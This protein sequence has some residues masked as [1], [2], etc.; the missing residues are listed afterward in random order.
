M[1][2]WRNTW[3]VKQGKMDE[4]ITA[5]KETIEATKAV[6]LDLGGVARLYTHL[7]GSNELVYEEV[8]EDEATQA[9]FWEAYNATPQAAAF[10]PKWFGLVEPDSQKT[11]VWQVTEWR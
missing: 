7:D 9:K 8:W 11:V 4:A 10:W 5:L 3:T 1:I 6:A 2:A